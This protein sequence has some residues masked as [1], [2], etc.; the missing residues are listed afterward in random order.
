MKN[1]LTRL[2]AIFFV[3]TCAA[4]AADHPELKHFPPAKEGMERFVIVLPEKQRGEEDAFRV[5]IVAGKTIMT[6]GANVYHLGAAIESRDL[7]G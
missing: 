4:P 3:A 2:L 1:R 7:E 6:D 5:E